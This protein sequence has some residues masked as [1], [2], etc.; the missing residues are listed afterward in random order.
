MSALGRF[1]N[2][3]FSG[4]FQLSRRFPTALL[5]ELAQVI[6]AGERTHRGE[7]CMAIE[8]RLEPLAVLEGL[9]P[10]MR[11]EQ[12]FAEQRVWNTEH[13]SGVLLYV[14]MAEQRIEILADRGIAARVPAVEW[15]AICQSMQTH[16]GQGAWRD[17]CLEGVAAVQ[18]LLQQHFPDDGSPRENELPNRPQLL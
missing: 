2:N 15:T 16:F 1:A 4:W 14:L 5:D 18:A 11:V 12:V 9:T 17:G 7:I 13:N 3:V 10:R 8:S 6:A